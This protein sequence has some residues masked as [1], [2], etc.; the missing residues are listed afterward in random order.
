MF[1]FA[2]WKI[3][4]LI[5]FYLFIFVFISFAL[6]DSSLKNITAIYIK[7]CAAYVFL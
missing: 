1:S 5:R 2:L 6:G 3:L 7:I 4:I